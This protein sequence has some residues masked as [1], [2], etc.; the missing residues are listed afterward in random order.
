MRPGVAVLLLL[1]AVAGSLDAI[2]YVKL[3]GVFVCNQTG[4]ILLLG[5]SIAEGSASDAAT[6]AMS[7][8]AFI[9][10]AGLAGRLVPPLRRGARWPTR[11]ATAIAIEVGAIGATTSLWAAGASNAVAVGPIAA[12][13]GVQATLARRVALE[14]LTSGFLTGTLST[15]AMTSPLGD[16]SNPWWWYALAPL[17]VLTVAAGTVS[18]VAVESVSWALGIAAAL[19]LGAWLVSWFA[20][21]ARRSTGP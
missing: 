18:I 8:A 12:A 16:N 9:F 20:T 5:I 21:G 14:H 1:T 4:N 11:T 19:A 6:G 15:A 7:F 17:V 10:A 13:M 3:G 2:A